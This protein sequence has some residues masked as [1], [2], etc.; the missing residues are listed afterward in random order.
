LPYPEGAA[1]IGLYRLRLVDG[2][3]TALHR[4]VIGAE[5]ADRIGLTRSVAKASRFS[6]YRLFG[7]A[8]FEIA[9]GVETLRARSA[10]PEEARLLE[11]DDDPVVMAV[12][13]ETRGRDG[14]LL[15][16]VDAVYDAR[17]YSYQAEIR[18]DPFK[19][20]SS[21]PP[22]KATETTH[23]ATSNLKRHFGP[24][25]GPWRDDGGGRG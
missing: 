4:S 16:V 1:L 25:I 3:P 6:L 18:R 13:R 24:R 8:G 12:R 5:L 2:E 14:A 9:R 23:E 17:R 15:D 20:L 11:I 19:S 7:Q 22:R 10:T 21:S